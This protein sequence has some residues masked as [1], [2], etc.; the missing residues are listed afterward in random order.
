M[1]I[2][3]QL[4]I[5]AYSNETDIGTCTMTIASLSNFFPYELPEISPLRVYP[6]S[7]IATYEDIWQAVK[8]VANNC[9]SPFFAAG[10]AQ[11]LESSSLQFVSDTGF[12]VTGKPQ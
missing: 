2:Q 5:A 8:N 7:D 9:I 12:G 10:A 4:Y 3:D 11:S 6:T 1:V